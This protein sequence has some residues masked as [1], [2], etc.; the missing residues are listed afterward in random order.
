MIKEDRFKL[1]NIKTLFSHTNC[2]RL[3]NDIAFQ[4]YDTIPTSSEQ[5]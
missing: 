1:N 5:D 3:N 2:L 4:N